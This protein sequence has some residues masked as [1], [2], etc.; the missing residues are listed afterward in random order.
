MLVDYKIEV[1]QIVFAKI[2]EKIDVKIRASYAPY[3]KK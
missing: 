1:P 2:A 3:K